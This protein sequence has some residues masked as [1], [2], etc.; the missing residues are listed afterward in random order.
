[1]MLYPYRNRRR[2]SCLIE[3]LEKRQL[4]SLTLDVR[5]AG[6]AKSA[7]VTSVGQVVN[8]EA[9][10]VVTGSNGNPAD[11]GVQDIIGSFLSS[12]VSGGGGAN[13]TLRVTRA[14]PFNGIGSQ[15]G[16]QR[17][18]DG[19]GDLDVGSNTAG[20]VAN[21]FFG[22]ST[23]LTLTGGT[24]SGNTHSYKVADLTFTVTSLNSGQTNINFNPEPTKPTFPSY[25]TAVWQEDGVRKSTTS[26]TSNEAAGYFTGSPVVLTRDGSGGGGGGGGTVNPGSISGMVWQDTNANGVKDGSEGAF[27]NFTLYIDSN[28]NGLKDSGEPATTTNSSGNYTFSN[29]AGNNSYRVR[30]F[31]P[32]G[33]GTS[34]PAQPTPW[35]DVSLGSG[36]AAAGK[37]FGEKPTTS[38]PPPTQAGSISGFVWRDATAN[39]FRDASEAAF[40]GFDLYI[41]S[42][43]NGVRDS[44]E[45]TAQTNGSGFYT[46]SNLSGNANY[47]VRAFPPSGFGTSYPF[48][49]TPWWDVFVG[50]GQNVSGKDFGEKSTVST[51]AG[52]ISGLVW[53]D[54]TINGVKDAGESV[55]AGF[56]LYID[57]NLNGIFD[58]GERTTWAD[59]NGNY[60]FSN[61][62]GNANYRVR[63]LPPSGWRTGT[64]GPGNPWW[65]VF[66]ASGQ[67][68]TGKNFGERPA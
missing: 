50:S 46:F 56:Q 13:G 54:T 58:S 67:N 31:P 35:W 61:L 36:T 14:A 18:L 7:A 26:A 43:I 59:S 49:P 24:S 22:R 2:S 55:F 34:S 64:A 5:V 17:D 8:L 28:R 29:L 63:A 65:D 1:M 4:M 19:D 53:K 48:Q 21:Y 40:I 6:G 9:W 62:P 39:G 42:N 15:D 23:G 33:W 25:A 11:D 45:P 47:R 3:S 12:N 37:N 27:S 44:G 52:S 20:D 66:V 32:G 10:A 60:F 41:D 57:G 30:A 16:V 68:L 51:S 38:Q